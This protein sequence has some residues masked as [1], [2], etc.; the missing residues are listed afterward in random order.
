MIRVNYVTDDLTTNCNCSN[1]AALHKEQKNGS[2][3]NEE[4]E[5][6]EKKCQCI[7]EFKELNFELIKRK[8]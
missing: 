8:D 2:P 1:D 6:I 3:D 5:F 4:T 7:F